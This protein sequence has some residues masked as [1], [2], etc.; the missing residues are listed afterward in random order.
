MTILS[1]PEHDPNLNGT[2]AVD[3]VFGLA[4]NDTLV[5]DASNDHLFGDSGHDRLFDGS[6]NDCLNASQRFAVELRI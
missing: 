5:G 3:T 2:S 6:G 1:T 4:G